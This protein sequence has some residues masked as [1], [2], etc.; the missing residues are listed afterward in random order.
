MQISNSFS[1]LFGPIIAFIGIGA[2]VLVLR[3]AYARGTSL[4]AAPAKAGR[5]D[6][7]GL[8]VC[9]ASPADYIQGEILRRKLESHGI[10]ANLAQTVEG[11]K[12]MVWPVDRDRANDLLLD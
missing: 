10:R 12:V 7:Y 3:W 4:V 2:M 9:V 6:E 1:Y 11:P 5:T 8:L